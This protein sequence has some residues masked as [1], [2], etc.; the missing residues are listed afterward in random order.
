M[1]Q[2]AQS[3]I[4]QPSKSEAS[5]SVASPPAELRCGHWPRAHS[6]L[7]RQPL[8]RFAIGGWPLVV[9]ESACRG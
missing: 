5:L 1:A 7:E 9:S 4:C 2:K 8:V 6:P 3:Q